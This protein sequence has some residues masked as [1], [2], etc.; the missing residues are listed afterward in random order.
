MPGVLGCCRSILKIG[1]KADS[2]LLVAVGEISKTFL[3]SRIMGMVLACGSVGFWNPF[4]SI[5]FRTGFTS[6]S[7]IFSEVTGKREPLQKIVFCWGIKEVR[8]QIG[9]QTRF[10]QF[11]DSSFF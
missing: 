6:I 2:V 4:C 1:R 11:F 8:Q 5:S 7:K 10:K 9:I 3:P